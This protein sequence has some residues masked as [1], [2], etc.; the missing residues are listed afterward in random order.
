[1]VLPV[2][3]VFPCLVEDLEAKD[4]VLEIL[5]KVLPRD[6]PADISEIPRDGALICGVGALFQMPAL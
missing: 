3:T 5:A 2:A 4:V 6:L 1:L